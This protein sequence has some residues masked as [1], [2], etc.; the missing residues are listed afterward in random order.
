MGRGWTIGGYFLPPVST[1]ICAQQGFLGTVCLHLNVSLSLSPLSLRVSPHLP[2][3][4]ASVLGTPW[5]QCCPR[6]SPAHLARCHHLF[7]EAGKIH[8]PAGGPRAPGEGRRRAQEWARREGGS[9]GEQ[10]P[11]AG[12]EEGRVCASGC[13]Q[14]RA[15]PGGEHRPRRQPHATGRA[16]PGPWLWGTPPPSPRPLPVATGHTWGSAS[17]SLHVC[18]PFPLPGPASAPHVSG[19]CQGLARARGGRGTSGPRLQ[20]AP[21]GAPVPGARCPSAPRPHCTPGSGQR[22]KTVRT[23]AGTLASGEK[24]G[25]PGHVSRDTPGSLR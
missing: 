16:C 10:A 15:R 13:A 5:L 25:V 19:H 18:F 20:A 21:K 3:G 4:C 6:L 2:P 1:S 22:G 14:P 12:G 23:A 17:L 8:S 11:G 7:T 24:P 9:P